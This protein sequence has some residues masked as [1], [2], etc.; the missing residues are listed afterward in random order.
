MG[1]KKNKKYKKK[2]KFHGNRFVQVEI[3]S[4]MKRKL[5]GPNPNIAADNQQETCGTPP[6]SKR[7]RLDEVIGEQFEDYFIIIN[8]KIMKEMI[9]TVG[10]CLDCV[11]Q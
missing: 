9:S 8:F 11:W 6:G 2:S 1:S 5:N 10:K 4:G 3:G 7:L